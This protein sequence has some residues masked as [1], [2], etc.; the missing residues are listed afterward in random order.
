[1]TLEEFAA[2]WGLT[3]GHAQSY[4]SRFANLKKEGKHF[5]YDE[6]K[7]QAAHDLKLIGAIEKQPGEVDFQDIL[8]KYDWKIG[9]NKLSKLVIS[10]TF[11]EVKRGCFA[12][13]NNK[14]LWDSK[15]VDEFFNDYNSDF[16]KRQSKRRKR[17]F[18]KD[19]SMMIC[20]ITKQENKVIENRFKHVSYLTSL[21]D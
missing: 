5:I 14:R 4:L 9:Y 8:K 11:P 18:S 21:R 3:K 1:M 2:H 17:T 15:A 16:K 13:S 12:G 19:T 7:I 20:F 10:D 6:A